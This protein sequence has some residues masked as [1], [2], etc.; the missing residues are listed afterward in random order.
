MPRVNYTDPPHMHT[1][2]WQTVLEP[3]QQR[4]L[5]GLPV[6][7]PVRSVDWKVE[8]DV[9]HCLSEHRMDILML[10]I[11]DVN[12][13]VIVDIGTAVWTFSGPW[14]QRGAVV[15][16]LVVPPRQSHRLIV[17][18]FGNTTTEVTVHELVRFRMHTGRDDEAD[19]SRRIY[20]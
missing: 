11:S 17:E 7:P 16:S 15:G 18:N 1:F 5:F 14:Y 2:Q 20:R 19:R 4:S 9:M 8:N 13:R 10:G 3:R 12:C 6:P